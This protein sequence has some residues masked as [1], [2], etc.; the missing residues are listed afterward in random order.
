MVVAGLCIAGVSGLAI[1]IIGVLYLTRPRM[2]AAAFG[3]PSI[4]D[5]AETPWLRLK[6]VR[7]LATGI[8]AG[9]LLITASPFVIG[10]TLLAFALIPLGDMFTVLSAKG[11]ASAAWGIHGATALTLIL[12]AALLLAGS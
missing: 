3:L 1:A 6:G 11:R 10:W 8:V 7:D 5:A 9:V 12:G 2:I 4:P